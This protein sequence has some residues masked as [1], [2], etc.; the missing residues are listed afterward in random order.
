MSLMQTFISPTLMVQAQNVRREETG[1]IGFVNINMVTEVELTPIK[2][3]DQSTQS[4]TVL[5]D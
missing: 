2:D 5:H 1:A 4:L 3:Q